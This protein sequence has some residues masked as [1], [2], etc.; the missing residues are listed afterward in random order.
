MDESGDGCLGFK[1]VCSGLQN[2]TGDTI[3]EDDAKQIVSNVSNMKEGE[4]VEIED[5]GISIK[6]FLIS[7]IDY[8]NNDSMIRYLRNAYI[9]FFNN[10]FE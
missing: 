10:E 6:D 9:L 4:G 7:C 3:S 2:I 1:E 5:L 8:K